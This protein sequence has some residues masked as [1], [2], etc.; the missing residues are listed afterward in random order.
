MRKLHCTP[1]AALIAL[2]TVSAARAQ[3]PLP[4]DTVINSTAYQAVQQYHRFIGHSAPIYNGPAYLV[5]DHLLFSGHPYFQT[6]GFHN[7]YIMYDNILY[8]NVPLKFDVVKDNIVTS[9]PAGVL[10]F[11]LF[12]EKIRYFNVM[13]HTFVRI[14]RDSTHDVSTGFY[15][16][17][18]RGSHVNLYRKDFKKIWDDLSAS[19]AGGI[20]RIVDSSSTYYVNMNNSF[21]SVAGRKQL[22]N[23]FK[24][25]RPEIRQ[26]IRKNK[27]KFRRDDRE[28]SMIRTVAYY[29]SLTK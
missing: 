9:E 17:L 23:V 13:G 7:G 6:V 10:Q 26:F 27:F 28:S 16:E 5:Y 18:Y 19:D 11:S 22:L 21:H 15:D 12:N 8:E 29:D 25:K 2:M 4:L 24:D 3:A 20:R 14:V 1:I